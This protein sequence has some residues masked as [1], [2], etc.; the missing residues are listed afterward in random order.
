MEREDSEAVSQAAIVPSVA[1]KAQLM[2]GP[3]LTQE[4][5]RLLLKRKG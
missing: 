3:L 4:K 1:R 5:E 2:D